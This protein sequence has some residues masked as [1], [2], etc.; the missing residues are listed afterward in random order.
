MT[1]SDNGW[2]GIA[3]RR[4]DARASSLRRGDASGSLRWH[5]SH[6]AQARSLHLILCRGGA[7]HLPSPE[8]PSA[9]TFSALLLPMAPLTSASWRRRTLG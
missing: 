6:L 8:P 1:E 4:R 2:T 9:A 3:S 7:T 5:S